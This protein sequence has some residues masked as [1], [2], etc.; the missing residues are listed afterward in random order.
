MEAM[1]SSEMSDD[2]QRTTERYIPEDSTLYN[3]CFENLKTYTSMK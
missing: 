3:N 2:S 1:C